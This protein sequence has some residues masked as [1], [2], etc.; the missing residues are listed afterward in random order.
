MDN[1]KRYYNVLKRMNLQDEQQI[2]DALRKK[3]FYNHSDIFPLSSLH[4]ELTEQCNAFCKH[5]YNNSGQSTDKQMS[6]QEW[7]DF[8]KY[9]ISKG[10]MFE[11]LISGGEPLLF[12]EDLFTIMDLLHDDGSIFLLMTNGYLLNE[13]IVQRLTKYKYHW[14]QISIDSYSANYHDEFRGL[15]GLWEK[16]VAGSIL[17]SKYNI[18]LKIAHCVTPYNVDDFDKMCELA[19]S[20]GASSLM[21]GGISLSGRSSL[22]RNYLLSDSD[23]AKLREKIRINRE[24]YKGKMQVRLTNTVKSGLIR[25]SKSP[26]SGAIIRPNGDIKIDGMAPFIVG[27]ILR[28][29]FS[30]IWREK[31]D[32]AW[33][34]PKVIE[35]IENYDLNDQNKRYINYF[36]EDIYL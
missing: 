31:V 17:V 21:A 8:T 24:K 26:R 35:Y 10:G 27:N 33:S 18:P 23:K 19:Y 7:I 32:L 25:H 2:S 15:T 12:G 6:R 9:I 14:I 4:F 28:D 16:A 34:H 5:C 22:H 30:D 20:V 13:Q 36:D 1:L 11:C 29:D 3:G